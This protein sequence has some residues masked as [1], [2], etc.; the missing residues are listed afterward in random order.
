MLASGRF[1][2]SEH[3]HSVCLSSVSRCFS[4]SHLRLSALASS[5]AHTPSVVFLILIM[6]NWNLSYWH[7]G[8]WLSVQFFPVYFLPFWWSEFEFCLPFHVYFFLFYLSHVYLTHSSFFLAVFFLFYNFL[9]VFF[10]NFH[11][12]TFFCPFFRLFFPVKIYFMIPVWKCLQNYS[13]IW[14]PQNLYRYCFIVAVFLL[15]LLFSW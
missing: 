8:P 11:K 4:L 2:W 6:Q 7:T 13:N 10:S 5:N 12:S 14:S 9:L 1:L 3:M 15:K